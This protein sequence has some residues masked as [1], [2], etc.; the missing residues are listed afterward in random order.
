MCLKPYL[1]IILRI[2]GFKFLNFLK[3]KKWEENDM[4]CPDCGTEYNKGAIYC[5]FCGRKLPHQIQTEKLLIGKNFCTQCGA[6]HSPTAEYCPRCGQNLQVSPS[7]Q[8]KALN[9]GEP[10]PE[11]EKLLLIIHAALTGFNPPRKILHFTDQNIYVTKGTL[12]VGGMVET[13]GWAA[14]GIIGG[15]IGKKYE[16]DKIAE[17]ERAAQSINFQELA[18]NDPEVLVI[19]YSEI[20]KFT[21]A[22]KSRLLSPTIS[23][24]TTS[25]EYN[26]TITQYKNYKQHCE[27]IPQILGDKVIIQ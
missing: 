18:A 21:L 7:D 3:L 20:I 16:K 12:I 23:I 25:D 19:P 1:V 2:N 5:K 17:I 26:Y 22:R 11:K 13:L 4:F 9:F 15:Q 14:G 8:G 27:I 10:S 6:E 24:Q